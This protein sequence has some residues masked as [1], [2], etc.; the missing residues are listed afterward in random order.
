LPEPAATLPAPF[1]KE[2]PDH[3]IKHI[4]NSFYLVFAPWTISK[5]RNTAIV[6]EGD[7]MKSEAI[8]FVE[9][10]FSGVDCD[11]SRGIISHKANHLLNTG[12]AIA[13]I[14]IRELQ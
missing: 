3:K 10:L 2:S 5:K 14:L 12:I 7:F 8:A 11:S 9:I 1:R 13:A 6:S 4:P